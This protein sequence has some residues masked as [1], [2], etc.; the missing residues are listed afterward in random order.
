MK[1][2][3]TWL[4][5]FLLLA[6]AGLVSAQSPK[7]KPIQ[8]GYSNFSNVDTMTTMVQAS[9]RKIIADKGVNW[10]VSY[11]DARRDVNNQINQVETFI[12]QKVDVI[13]ISAVDPAGSVA[14]VEAAY[15]ANIPIL[16]VIVPVK[17]DKITYVGNSN[18][19][20]GETLAKFVR[21]KLAPNSKIVIIEGQAGGVNSI[22]R[23]ESFKKTLNRP[24]VKILAQNH[25][26]WQREKGMKLMEDWIQAFPQIDAVIGINDDMALGAIEALK[27]AN[28]LKGVMVTGFNGTRDAMRAVK[29]GS[30]TCTM[31]YN[32]QTQA[33]NL[34]NAVKKILDEKLM[35]LPHQ[36]GNWE[37]V[38]SQNAAKYL[39]DLYGE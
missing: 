8:I 16:G 37:I 14:A 6:S 1:I 11:Q 4:L 38:T 3:V 2:K 31:L 30:M 28:R 12:A 17:S 18:E 13:I 23:T 21:D 26:D 9:F 20:G 25:A 19:N 39:K 34:F 36:Y 5:V 15:K 22:Q 10:V 33:Q 32:A 35:V 24:D 27:G 7:G 29:E